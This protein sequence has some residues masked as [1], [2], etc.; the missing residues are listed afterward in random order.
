VEIRAASGGL[1][2]ALNVAI[3]VPDPDLARSVDPLD[4]RDATSAALVAWTAPEP[5]A[6]DLAGRT[7]RFPV[8]LL[9][10]GIRVDEAHPAEV[11]VPLPETLDADLIADLSVVQGGRVLGTGRAP[12]TLVDRQTPIELEVTLTARGAAEAKARLGAASG[13]PLRER[14]EPLQPDLMRLRPPTAAGAAGTYRVPPDVVRLLLNPVAGHAEPLGRRAHPLQGLG[15]GASLTTAFGLAGEPDPTAPRRSRAVALWIRWVGAPDLAS[16]LEARGRLLSSADG[17]HTVGVDLADG[18]ARR[19]SESEVVIADAFGAPAAS[20]LL[21]R[22][23]IERPASPAAATPPGGGAI[24]RAKAR[25]G[26][27]WQRWS[28]PGSTSDRETPGT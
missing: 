21:A 23:H 22:R 25:L 5:C 6:A 7:L 12:V 26:N 11:I 3:A 2:Q 18:W 1:E 10:R 4:V 20:D 14:R 15:V 16:D 19:I 24:A 17:A 28:P 13:P 8:R 9:G 27:L